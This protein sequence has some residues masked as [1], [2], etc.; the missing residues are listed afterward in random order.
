MFSIVYKT[1]ILYLKYIHETVNHV[2]SNGQKLF[3][4]LI[5]VSPTMKIPFPHDLIQGNL[6]TPSI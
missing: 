2:N 6:H 1:N 5:P 4:M 3:K